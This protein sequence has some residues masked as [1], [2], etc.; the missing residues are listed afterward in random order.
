MYCGNLIGGKVLLPAVA[1]LFLVATPEAI[2]GARIPRAVRVGEMLVLVI[3]QEL[4][5]PGDRRPR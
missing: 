3:P 5:D 4:I 2:E 1:L